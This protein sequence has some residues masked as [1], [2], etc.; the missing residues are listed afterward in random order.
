[1]VATARTFRGTGHRVS[2]YLTALYFLGISASIE[3]ASLLGIF[4]RL[5]RSIPALIR[6][7]DVFKEID[8]AAKHDRQSTSISP[9]LT[10]DKKGAS[11]RRVWTSPENS[12]AFERRQSLRMI[13]RD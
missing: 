5:F 7:E 4:F 1:M 3:S 2:R 9:A 13:H 10:A 6:T 8:P 11:F 12:S